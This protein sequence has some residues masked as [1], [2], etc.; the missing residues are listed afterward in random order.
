VRVD[1]PS[2]KVHGISVLAAHGELSERDPDLFEPMGRVVRRVEFDRA[3]AAEAQ[4]RGIRVIEQAR[5]TR[6]DRD[7]DGVRIEST[8]GALRA[9]AVA[10]A[11]GVGSFVRKAIGAPR[12]RWLA[13]VIE[14]DT[15]RAAGDRARDLLHFDLTDRSLRG[16]A[17]DFPTIV[18]GRELVCRGIYELR[19]G[20]EGDA[21]SGPDL[22]D[23]LG[24]RLAKLGVR[25]EGLRFKR[26]A[27]RGLSLHEPMA[28]PRAL[29][30]GEAAGID[31]ALG[32]G[33][34]QAILYGAIAGPY[35]AR[36]L[37]RGDLG[38]GDWPAVVRRSR[39]GLDLRLR[40]GA[41]P[42]LY[43]RTRAAAER[44]VT[45]SKDLALAGIR[46]FAGERVPRRRLVRA[47]LDLGRA[48][49]RR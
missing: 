9:R 41:T 18:D 31:P 25:A 20:R 3:L 13:Q 36:C 46:Y 23:R 10:G 1:V 42:W 24:S 5:V 15:E 26:F 27:E 29:L 40:A 34:A 32:E 11:D 17:W 37:D 6:V 39:V 30:V 43:G 19:Q 33:I 49:V 45:G 21:S 38:F 16:Y 47:A 44:W 28:R 48:I 4:A 12:G 2:A 22:G 14:V 35:L 7:R 8:A